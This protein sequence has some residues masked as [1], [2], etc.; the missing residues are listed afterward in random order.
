STYSSGRIGTHRLLTHTAGR[1]GGLRLGFA[2]PERFAGFGPGRLVAGIPGPWAA[3][4]AR[5]VPAEHLALNDGG[6]RHIAGP[7]LRCRRTGPCPRCPAPQADQ[8]WL[9]LHQVPQ[10]ESARAEGLEQR[11]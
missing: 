3:P 2:A 1:S 4:A 7:G 6:P 11:P 10:A 9:G 5:L 8:R